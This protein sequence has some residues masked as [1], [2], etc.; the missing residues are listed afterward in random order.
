MISI[1]YGK[2]R[3][4]DVYLLFKRK[5]DVDSYLAHETTPKVRF[6][7]RDFVDFQTSELDLNGVTHNDRQNLSIETPAMYDFA[8]N[9]ILYDV[10]YKISWRITNAQI[11]DD[12]QMKENSMR[13]RK[14][15]RLTLIR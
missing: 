14:L 10:K 7:G 15:T 8:N 2:K 13:P 11:C 5:E 4:P 12:G 1:G 6:R 9:D 3:Y